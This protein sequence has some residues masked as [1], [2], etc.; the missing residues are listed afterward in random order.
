[1]SILVFEDELCVFVLEVNDSV[2]ALLTLLEQLVHEQD[3]VA[4]L[5][6]D[7]GNPH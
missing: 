7:F 4:F 1:M 5:A 6:L 2:L 3:V